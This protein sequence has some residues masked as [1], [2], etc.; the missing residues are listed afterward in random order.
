MEKVMD[1]SGIA[2]PITEQ[3]AA[4]AYDG[5]PDHRVGARH[6]VYPDLTHDEIERFNFL[7]QVNR[8]LATRVQPAV[9]G[10]W[11]A[12]IEPRFEAEHGRKPADRQEARK[13]L[14]ADPVFQTWSA[15]K[16][17][18][19]EQRQQ[20]GRW[21]SI[22]QAESLAARAA[23]LVTGD[24]LSLDAT[25][26]VP[27]YVSAI[28]HHCMPGS[29]HTELFPGDVS[30]PA[31]YDSGIHVTVGG[32]GGAYNDGIG[33]QM[34]DWLKTNLPDFKPR[35]I[36]DL[37]ATT[38]HNLLPMAQAFP[39]AEVI[40]VDVGTPVLRYAAARAC[41]LGVPN[42]RFVQADASHLPQFEDASFDFVM[43]T[44][45]LHELSLA[46]MDAIFHEAHRLLSPGGLMLNM[47]QP[48]YKGMPVFEQTMRDWDAFYNNEPFWTTLH[49]LELDD[50][51]V[52][53]GFDRD[54]LVHVV[55]PSPPG[56]SAHRKIGIVYVG[57]RK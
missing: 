38:G 55:F 56:A 53:A 21:A 54:K 42:V 1:G 9:E 57:A 41:A 26:A 17:M 19:M 20:A 14:L 49:G 32:R 15:L 35:R 12:R 25:I 50:H 3:N 18:T 34:A 33:R 16:R 10:T 13:A 46:A 4:A 30:G 2:P 31:N 48:A 7:A 44:M 43:S 11:E 45:F 6:A 22:R 8:H 37:G 28:D 5:P 23:G 39:D 29:Y 24:R 47:E 40:G 36:L 51:F 27:R 52:D